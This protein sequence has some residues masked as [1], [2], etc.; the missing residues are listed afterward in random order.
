MPIDKVYPSCTEAVADIPDGASIMIGG[1]T[2]IGG[3]PHQLILALRDQG[4]KGL[5]IIANG[6][7]ADPT[8]K[9]K[10][11]TIPE[12]DIGILAENGQVKKG[13]AS[14][15]VSPSASHPTAFEKLYLEGRVEVEA[16]PQGTFCERMRIA[17][18]GLG[19]FYTRV[20]VG[21]AVEEG[22]EKRVFDGQDYILELPLRADYALIKAH[23]ADRMGNLVYKGTSRN[24]NPLM[25]AAAKV[26]IV[27]V[28]QIVEIG[29]LDPEEI[30]T[31][32]VYV[33][34]VVQQTDI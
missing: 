13:I 3:M 15:P 7:G 27:Q 1:F 23:R 18:A 12:G 24:F 32:G 14:F 16:L 9:R 28:E 2:S 26:T 20:G 29:G 11:N 4:A 31:P 25:A 30:I 22:K 19:G 34:R 6:L 33:D 21:T 10:W 5:T 17:A 8:K